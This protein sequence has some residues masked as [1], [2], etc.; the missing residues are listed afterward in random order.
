M[1]VGFGRVGSAFWGFQLQDGAVPDIV[2][3]GKRKATAAAAAA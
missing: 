3:M 1:Q 2:T